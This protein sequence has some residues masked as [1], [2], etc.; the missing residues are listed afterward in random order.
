MNSDQ[1]KTGLYLAAGLGVAYLAF[2][3]YKTA[4]GGITWASDAVGGMVN[5]AKQLG[6]E[7]TQAWNN[8]T[9]VQQPGDPVKAA[10]YGNRGY[11][12]TDETGQSPLAGEWFG[13]AEGRR[14]SY[15]YR[16]AATAQGRP[17]PVESSNGAAFGIYPS[18]GRRPAAAPAPAAPPVND[19]I[20]D[21][22]DYYT[23]GG[24]GAGSGSGSEEE[25][26]FEQMASPMYDY[27]AL[28]L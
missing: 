28:R 18:A 11:E 25:R 15:Q 19:A 9:T 12:G 23:T 22:W 24:R 21:R 27:W 16:D 7:I 26:S 3:T 17:V 20:A 5:G 8:A 2:R 6:A 13:T 1:V 10:L 14:Y 4:A